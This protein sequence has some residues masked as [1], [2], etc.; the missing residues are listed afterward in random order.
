MKKDDF[1]TQ[2]F[3]VV[4]FVAIEKIWSKKYLLPD[5]HSTGFLW[6]GPV[7]I[8]MYVFFRQFFQLRNIAVVGQSIN[9]IA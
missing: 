2:D 8:A 3:E 5:F 9:E 1:E 4:F 6:D 7:F